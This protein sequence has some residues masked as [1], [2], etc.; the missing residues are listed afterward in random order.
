MANR[1][2][3]KSRGQPA[4]RIIILVGLMAVAAHHAHDAFVAAL[5]AE[6]KPE[7]WETFK[8]LHLCGGQPTATVHTVLDNA[9]CALLVGLKAFVLFYWTHKWA[10]LVAAAAIYELCKG[11]GELKQMAKAA[12]RSLRAIIDLLF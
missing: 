8:E 3:P 10:A 1:K 4:L 12:F 6:I 9:C 7:D 11:V 5:N 2:N